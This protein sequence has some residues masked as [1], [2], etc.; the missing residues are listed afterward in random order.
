VEISSPECISPIDAIGYLDKHEELFLRVI[1]SIKHRPERLTMVRGPSYLPHFGPGRGPGF[2]LGFHLNFNARFSP[3]MSKEFQAVMVALLP[4]IGCGGLT[5]KGFR[6]SPLGRMLEKGYAPRNGILQNLNMLQTGT[7]IVIDGCREGEHHREYRLHLPC[8]D[9]PLTRRMTATLFNTCQF[10]ITLLL[11]GERLLG[12]TRP[13]HLSRAYS[14][15]ADS[16]YGRRFRLAGGGL[17][18]VG[19]LQEELCASLER[20]RRQYCL[21]Q[22]QE[23]IVAELIQGMEAFAAGDEDYL[24]EHFDGFLKRKIYQS[25]LEDEGVSPQW[26]DSIVALVYRTCKMGIDLHELA[27]LGGKEAEEFIANT[28]P[29]A[30]HI[31]SVISLLQHYH[32]TAADIPALAHVLQRILTLEIGLYRLFPGPSPLDDYEERTW[33]DFL[34]ATGNKPLRQAPSRGTRRGE[35][36]RSIPEEVRRFCLAD[37]SGI[38]M[39]PTRDSLGIYSLPSPYSTETNL[40]WAEAGKMEKLLDDTGVDTTLE[41][42]R[43]LLWPDHEDQTNVDAWQGL[44]DQEV[45]RLHSIGAQSDSCQLQFLYHRER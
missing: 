36:I 29:D 45:R 9:R 20:V 4:L 7:A 37:W 31:K 39:L 12:K 5:E 41:F 15:I 43:Y 34:K 16:E 8:F 44:S 22:A 33:E 2:Q 23:Y 32:L 25:M 38:Y 6:T 18:T 27:L 42:D 13:A 21:S 19:S 40:V 14:I 28:K 26:F 17:T 1:G 30:R 24:S 3:A 11:Y 10:L 35:L